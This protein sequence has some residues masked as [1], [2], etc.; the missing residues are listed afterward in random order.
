[1]PG[2]E[3]NLYLVCLALAALLGELWTGQQ[4]IVNQPGAI[5]PG[6]RRSELLARVSGARV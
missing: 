2:F 1:L 5:K 4:L 3:D 6:M